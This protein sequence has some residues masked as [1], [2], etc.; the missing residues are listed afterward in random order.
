MNNNSLYLI[1]IIFKIFYIKKIETFNINY[2]FYMTKTIDI[3]GNKNINKIYKNSVAKKWIKPIQINKT[4]KFKD[5]NRKNNFIQV[6]NIVLDNEI[7]L[8]GIKKGI[9]KRT[10]LIN[11]I[12]NIPNDEYNK[13]SEWLYIFTINDRIVKI[14]GTRIGIKGRVISYLSGHYIEERG[15][16]GDCSKTNGYIYNTFEFYLNLGCKIQMYGY[17][18]PNTEVCINIFNKKINITPQ[19]FHAYE[20]AFLEDFKKSYKKYP[21]LSENCD[22]QYKKVI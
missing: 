3:S 9:K 18:L 15:K 8:K 21:I 13:K 11:F 14:G 5:Y 7:G 6:A 1:L 17:K 16:S 12:P 19:T 2:N 20:S 22:P 10:T 4:I